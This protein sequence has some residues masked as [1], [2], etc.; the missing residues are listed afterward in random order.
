MSDMPYAGARPSGDDDAPIAILVDG[1]PV[2]A[3]PGQTVAVALMAAGLRTLRYSRNT[4]A[5]RGVYCGMGVCYDC[6]VRID[7]TTDRACMR[8]VRDGMRVERIG[9]PRPGGRP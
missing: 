7:D 1:E 9:R 5:A 2:P 6:V 4:G 3:R 8:T